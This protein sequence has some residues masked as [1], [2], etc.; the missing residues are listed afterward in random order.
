[1]L[2]ISHEGAQEM[3]WL[4]LGGSFTPLFVVV[5]NLLGKVLPMIVCFVPAL[6]RNHWVLALACAGVV[7]GIFFMRYVTVFGGQVLPLM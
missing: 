4:V 5:E 6:R 3:T 1:V 7:I 2:S